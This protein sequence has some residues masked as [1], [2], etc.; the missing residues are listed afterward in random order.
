MVLRQTAPVIS[1]DCPYDFTS[2]TDGETV[3]LSADADTIG[4]TADILVIVSSSGR[5]SA[6]VVQV[7]T[8]TPDAPTVK[9]LSDLSTAV[10]VNRKVV[11]EGSVLH[12]S[13]GT[14]TWSYNAE[15]NEALTD[16]AASSTFVDFVSDGSV[17]NKLTLRPGALTAG[18]TY[19]F[20]FTADL[21]NGATAFS[22]VNV[23]V[24]EGPTPGSFQ[25]SP[26]IG[27]E[28]ETTFTVFSSGW[29]DINLPL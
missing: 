22:T 1:E 6:Q 21:L 27:T 7:Y 29:T 5:S 16:L 3:T 2:G 24:N 12:N 17:S 26:R 20:T 14:A 19:V 18:Q 9:I 25:V 11:I 10:N 4:V 28:I 13:T 8:V 23:V 15:A